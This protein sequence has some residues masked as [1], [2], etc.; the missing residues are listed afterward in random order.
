MATQH[1]MLRGFLLVLFYFLASASWASTQSRPAISG[2][3]VNSL[4]RGPGTTQTLFASAADAGAE[5]CKSRQVESSGYLGASRLRVVHSGVHPVYEVSCLYQDPPDQNGVTPPPRWNGNYTWQIS[6]SY[7]CRKGSLSSFPHTCTVAT[8]RPPQPFCPNEQG[9]PIDV[10]VKQKIQR[11]RDYDGPHGLQFTRQYNSA[12]LASNTFATG[13][14]HNFSKQIVS[15]LAPATM[16]HLLTSVYILDRETQVWGGG[17]PLTA[18]TSTEG[19]PEVLYLVR[20]DGNHMYFSSSDRG[21][22][23]ATDSDVNYRLEKVQIGGNPEQWR[24]TTPETDIEWYDVASGQLMEIQFRDGR[25]QKL[26]YSNESTPIHIAPRAGLLLK[27]E[28]NFARSLKFTWRPDGSL[29]SMTDPAEQEFVYGYDANAQLTSLTWPDGLMRLYHY[30]EAAY[31]PAQNSVPLKPYLTG[32]SNEIAPGLVLRHATFTYDA[33]GRPISTEH[34]GGVYKYT[35]NYGDNTVTDPLGTQRQYQFITQDGMIL[36][37]QISKPGGAGC[38][39]SM[40]QMSYDANLNLATSTD[41]NGTV[42]RLSYYPGNLIKTSDEAVGTAQAHKTSYEWHPVFRLPTRIAQAKLLTI[43]DYDARGNLLSTRRQ[44]T[45]DETGAQGLNPTVTG[46]IEEMRYSY[47]Q[48]GQIES[49]TELRDGVEQTTLYRY[50]PLDGN[51]ES[52]TDSANLVTRYSNYNAHGDVGKIEDSNGT[53]T[54]LS[55]FPRRWLQSRTETLADNTAYTTLFDYD[56]RGLVTRIARS[57]GGYEI[58]NYDDAGRLTHRADNFGNTIEYG[59]DPMGNRLLEQVRD[60]YGNVSHQVRRTHDALNRLQQTIY[61]QN[62]VVQ[63]SPTSMVL[64]S[65][66]NPARIG[67]PVKITATVSGTAPTG[68]VVLMKDGKNVAIQFLRGGSTTF[69]LP[70]LPLGSHSY[71]A[72]YAGD[73]KNHPSQTE[74][75]V[76]IIQNGITTGITLQCPASSVVDGAFTCT[77]QLTTAQGSIAQL[78]GQILEL[79]NGQVRVSS[80]T[81]E[82][83]EDGKTAS[84]TFQIRGMVVGQHTLQARYAGDATQLASQSAGFSHT[85]LGHSGQVTTFTVGGRFERDIEYSIIINCT[86]CAGGLSGNYTAQAG[87]TSFADIARGLTESIRTRVLS[88]PRDYSQ[89]QFSNVGDE[90]HVTA[91]IG[92]SFTPYSHVYLDNIDTKLTQEALAPRPGTRARYSFVLKRDRNEDFGQFSGGVDLVRYENTPGQVSVYASYGRESWPAGNISIPFTFGTTVCQGLIQRKPELDCG[93]SGDDKY[94]IYTPIGET[95]W[96]IRTSLTG[97]QGHY[98]LSGGWDIAA[99]STILTP[100]AQIIRVELDG[101]SLAGTTYSVTLDD[102][103]WHYIMKPGDTY[104]SVLSGLAAQIKSSQYVTQIKRDDQYS[105][106]YLSIASTTVVKP[107]T[108]SAAISTHPVFITIVTQEA[109]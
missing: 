51:L 44:A 19:Q 53:I 98:Q 104:E 52:V 99:E 71:S 67:Y 81:L 24:V 17:N 31:S 26:S 72:L 78:R 34:A 103:T 82:I 84:G 57:Q 100:Q 70:D 89:Y 50:N 109:R 68:E 47:N 61:G 33:K 69:E 86:P 25:W 59:L 65:N 63:D 42:T 1:R 14:R 94:Y 95:E 13:W 92:K 74:G 46:S 7:T 97:G 6:F 10:S 54:E 41:F 9:N 58:F 106:Y 2:Y 49:S 73:D 93:G 96:R 16:N 60:I 37:N 29:A 8:D 21:A 80:T 30:N 101:V 66:G 45:M 91:P 56:G 12:S 75:L 64:Q 79:F 36:T 107:F 32:I 90:I 83:S 5:F 76:Q 85:V 55:W 43:N 87:D 18:T 20:A 88:N 23:W 108:H 4:V 48:Y 3:H 102:Q 105:R 77:A 35:M 40:A 28:D 22:H 62:G 38:A 39:A 15:S 11:E 27:V